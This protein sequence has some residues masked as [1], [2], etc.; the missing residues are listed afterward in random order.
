MRTMGRR[1]KQI[2][3]MLAVMAAAGALLTQR[4]RERLLLEQAT[5]VADVRDWRILY[6]NITYYW[7][8]DHEVLFL[9]GSKYT[10]QRFFLRDLATGRETELMT[11][12]HLFE[13]SNGD[14]ADLRL[15][16]DGRW[17]L[18]PNFGDRLFA[19]TLDASRHLQWPGMDGCV[20]Y[21]LGDSHHLATFAYD[22]D[23]HKYTKATILSVDAP[24]SARTLAVASSSPLE[25]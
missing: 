9:R 2:M 7:V 25:L 18:W 10:P 12:G 17:L 6:P 22:D 23:R 8:S 3:M 20:T 14:P 15:S 21:W 5:R 1:G 4:P 24:R 11:L 13:N 19:A 16:P